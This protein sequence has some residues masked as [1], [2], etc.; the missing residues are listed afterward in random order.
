MLDSTNMVVVPVGNE[1]FANG[2]VL[3][4]E[5]L[6]ESGDPSRFPL[7]SV[8]QYPLP[9]SANEICVGS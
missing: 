3:F 7:A 1:R 8:N 5:G 4:S 6:F 9:T 2:C